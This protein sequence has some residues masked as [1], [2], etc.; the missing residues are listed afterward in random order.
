MDFR[1]PADAVGPHHALFD[2]A[3]RVCQRMDHTYT[4]TQSSLLPARSL[5]T[6]C[7]VGDGKEEGKNKYRNNKCNGKI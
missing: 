5:E 7:V 6:V 1:T 2:Q 4:P 3:I